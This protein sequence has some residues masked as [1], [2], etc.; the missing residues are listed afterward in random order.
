MQPLP[1]LLLA[2]TLCV[3]LCMASLSHAADGRNLTRAYLNAY[4]DPCAFG[5]AHV[6]VLRRYQVMLVLG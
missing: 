2:L 4:D 5:S 6:E 1:I 3:T